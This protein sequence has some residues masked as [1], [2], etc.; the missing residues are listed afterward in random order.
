M[1]AGLDSGSILS[2]NDQAS[3]IPQKTDSVEDKARAD[4][5]S[6]TYGPLTSQEQTDPDS[7]PPF[8]ENL[9]SGGFR[10]MMADG[11]NSS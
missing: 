5:R 6:G 8:G 2:S 10:G 9:F 1:A 4:W 11:L 7:L 3:S